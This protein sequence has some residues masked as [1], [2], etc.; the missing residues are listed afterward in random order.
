[1][2]KGK[3]T[4]IART[5]SQ[6]DGDRL[7]LMSNANEES[8][9]VV[10]TPA[11][12]ATKLNVPPERAQLVVRQRLFERL[13]VGLRGKLTLIAAPAG[14][15]K[16]TLLSAWRTTAT[17]SDMPFAWVSLDVAD[18]DPLTFWR[19]VLSAIETVA[20]GVTMPA[21]TLL[22]SPQAPTHET[23]LTAL[24]NNVATNPTIPENFVLVLDD[25]HAIDDLAVGQALTFLLEHLPP[26]M[27]LVIA[28]R[29]D[30]QL[31]LARF[32]ARNQL[33]ELR[34]Q[35]LRFTASEAA[36]F[37]NQVMGL[38]LSAEDIDA[39]EARTEGWIA[40]LQLAALAL[41]DRD[42]GGGRT[43]FI[44]T[45]TG[46]SRFIIDYLAEEV[47]GRQSEEVRS[48]L[49]RTSVLERMCAPLC[50]AALGDDSPQAAIQAQQMLEKSGEVQPVHR[51]TGQR[52]ALVPLSPSLC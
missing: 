47:L 3:G 13:E 18:N 42:D 15:G 45:F 14:F 7:A 19:Y 25:Y 34:A 30:P 46:S 35:D 22:L 16:T 51:S 9:I 20:P 38:E 52:A 50:D 40:G 4:G 36:G 33:T 5:T 11:L 48:F 41:R 49:L 32:R 24:L 17:G 6:V 10:G 37:L 8:S 2:G 21:M 31:P 1:M 43:A 12:L 23:V 29:E 26:R 27:H 39:L 28:T 44:R